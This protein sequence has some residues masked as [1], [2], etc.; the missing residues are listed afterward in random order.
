MCKYTHLPLLKMWFSVVENNVKLFMNR[1]ILLDV[2]KS[3]GFNI[4]HLPDRMENETN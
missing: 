1:I 3:C 2:Y 4:M